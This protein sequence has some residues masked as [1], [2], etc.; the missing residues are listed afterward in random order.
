MKVSNVA[1]VF[2]A[3]LGVTACSKPA[4]TPQPDASSAAP[5]AASVAAAPA[6]PKAFLTALYAHYTDS[7]SNFSPFDVPEN[8]FDPQLLSL[9][10]AADKATPDGDVGPLD[11][12]P[13]CDCQ[14]YDKLSADIT[15]KSEDAD[16]AV[17][18]VD[19]RD[20]GDA[21]PKVLTY[22]LAKVGGQWRIHDISSKDT[23]S[24]RKLFIN[25]SPKA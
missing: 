1:L 14:D 20:T 19:L 8:Y 25:A 23:P 5:A 12:D 18:V 15:I 3:A 4:S 11:G 13:I 22:H 21:K 6:D 10:D 7:K 16:T 9:M 2:M 17:A 24:L